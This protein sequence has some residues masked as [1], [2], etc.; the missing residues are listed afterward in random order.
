MLY[1]QS[2]S[3]EKSS[4]RWLSRTLAYALAVALPLLVLFVH[5]RLP[6][7]VGSRF[8]LIY[9]ALFFIA[10]VFGS[11]PA[12]LGLSIYLFSFMTQLFSP[13]SETEF[14]KLTVFAITSGFVIWIIGRSRSTEER[15]RTNHTL[16]RTSLES[17]GDAVILT[18]R[19]HLVM[20]MNPVAERLT[21]KKLSDVRCSPLLSVLSIEGD[22]LGNFS[23]AL[24]DVLHGKRSWESKGH[25][26]LVSGDG[27]VHFVEMSCGPI[28]IENGNMGLVIVL[29]DVGLV[30]AAQASLT[31]S[32][33]RLR[34]A[35]DV[36][37]LGIWEVN[38][39]TGLVAR[40]KNHDKIF[41]QQELLPK[42]EIRDYEARIH[43]EDLETVKLLIQTAIRDCQS[44][45]RTFR[46]L[47][48]DRSIRWVSATGKVECGTDGKPMRMIGT[49]M[50]VTEKKNS[51]DMLHEALFYRDEFLSI[52]SHELKTPL[53]SLKLQSQMFQRHLERNDR[54]AFSPDRIKRFMG[55]AD[56]Q[57]SRLTR[58]VDD[59]LDISR[60]R[61]GRLSISPE[62]VEIAAVVKD[63]VERM[64]P[65]FPS[66]EIGS[67]EGGEVFCD[68]LRIE[69]VI[70]NILNNALRYGKGRP[71][72]VDLRRD[73]DHVSIAV[74]DNGMGIPDEFRDKIF[75]RFQRAVPASEVSGLGLGLYI[76]KQIVEAHQGKISVES[77]LDQGSCF[78]VKIPRGE[79]VL[80]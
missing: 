56:K 75:T 20:F 47:R 70:T 74:T 13:G 16:F 39:L 15:L 42:W 22:S 31:Q 78:T 54:E 72:K 38:L 63:V 11:A 6:G 26:R 77:A 12:L 48:Q 80:Q 21:G 61:T 36:S 62:K 67:F 51:E 17:I 53:T 65:H 10:W 79:V 32:E 45:A 14:F 58:L 35:T 52:A 33:E 46:I 23:H 7:F 41:G 64:K 34:L 2:F 28:R 43:P 37:E 5:T 27:S 68:R 44:F 49:I 3:E 30:Q 1:L 8:V 50:D 59:M 4:S 76:S 60:I 24:T 29:K 55:E 57:V 73:G 25:S 40:N 18:D 69:Q 66:L 19:E 71:V 9:P